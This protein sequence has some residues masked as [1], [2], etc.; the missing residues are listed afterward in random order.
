MLK[1]YKGEVETNDNLNLTLNN[2]QKIKVDI[3][4]YYGNK[5]LKMII[6]MFL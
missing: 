6:K 3:F 1:H 4:A 5:L 2:H